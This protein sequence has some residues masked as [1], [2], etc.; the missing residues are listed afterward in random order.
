VLPVEQS[1]YWLA[2]REERTA[3]PKLQGRQQCE[4]AIVGAGF[5]G[6]WT[7]HFLRQLQPI[8]DIAIVEQS[9]C[10]YG[11]SGRNAGII[12]SSIDHSHSLAVAH[13]GKEDAAKLAK[14]GHANIRELAEF[15][16][17]C[18]VELTGQLCFA[19][20]PAHVEDLK[21][22]VETS[23][24]LEVAGGRVLSREE[25]Q[26]EV[27]SPIYLGAAYSPGGGIINPMKLV[28]KLR[29]AATASGARLLEQTKVI[30]IHGGTIT[31]LSGSLEAKKVVL[32]TDAYTHHLFPELLWRFI[33]LYDYAIVSEPLTAEQHQGIGWKN[34]QG[35]T[36]GRSFFNYYRLTADNRIVWGTSEAVYYPPNK[37]DLSCDHS[38]KHYDELRSSFN[39]HFPYLADLKFPYAWGGPI[40]STTRLT[41]FFGSLEGGQVIY[42]LGYTGHGI[43]TTRLAGKIL[44]HMALARNT[45]LA[46]LKMVQKK[47]FPY[48]PEPLR[49]LAVKAVTRSLQNVDAGGQPNA[50]LKVLDALGLGFSS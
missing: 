46:Q 38:Q 24:E 29:R 14:I 31:A 17:D 41:P 4:V 6:L 23:N 15:A 50:L 5:T 19:L 36:D 49:S 10:G 1:C 22:S 40:A 43:G 26:A 7:A 20:T 8:L 34:R 47:P 28:D 13:F 9:V 3:E 35:A 18:D 33:P 32:A 45:E 37:V 42:A 11:A 2:T 27:N 44:A 16:H 39:R 48:P 21:H 30:A 12:S 25:A